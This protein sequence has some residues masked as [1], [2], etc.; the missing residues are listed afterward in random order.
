M[1]RRPAFKYHLDRAGIGLLTL[2]VRERVL[3]LVEEWRWPAIDESETLDLDHLETTL[4]LSEI[5]NHVGPPWD[6]PY[7]PSDDKEDEANRA[8]ALALRLEL[9]A[10]GQLLR[11]YT[12]VSEY[13]GAERILLHPSQSLYSDDFV[14]DPALADEED[15]RR[16]V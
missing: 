16:V 3:E 5:A 2:G 15:R 12:E 7:I 10:R 1:R 14:F 6:A 11:G 8:W 9:Q 4:A 13:D